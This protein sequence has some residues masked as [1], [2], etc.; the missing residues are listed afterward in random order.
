MTPI[1]LKSKA[2]AQGLQPLADGTYKVALSYM[3]YPAVDSSRREAI[4]GTPKIRTGKLTVSKGVYS[5]GT[6]TYASFDLFKADLVG[7][8]FAEGSTTQQFTIE[9]D[10]PAATEKSAVAVTAETPW[11][12]I[13]GAAVVGYLLGKNS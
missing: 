7:K 8:T 1:V 12:L 2:D 13:I 11:G 9:E 3:E 4:T 10:A 6:E 5:T